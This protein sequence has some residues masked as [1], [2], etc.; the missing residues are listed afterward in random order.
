MSE[1]FIEDKTPSSSSLN[2]DYSS[3]FSYQFLDS[4]VY[5]DSVLLRGLSAIKL[6]H[7]TSGHTLI[8]AVIQMIISLTLV[9]SLEIQLSKP[10]AGVAQF[11]SHST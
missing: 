1:W 2:K 4:P 11:T 6:S 8:G 5:I 9:E 7:V 3:L 10:K